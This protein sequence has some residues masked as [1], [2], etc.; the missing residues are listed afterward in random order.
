MTEPFPNYL[1]PEPSTPAAYEPSQT[2]L[3]LLDFHVGI[4]QRFPDSTALSAV[5]MTAQLRHW[6]RAFGIIVIHAL[7][8]PTQSPAPTTKGAEKLSSIVADMV[9]SG[10]VAEPA[11]LVERRDDWDLT[12]T[13]APGVVSALQSPGLMDCLRARGIKSL[14]LCGLSTSGAVLRTAMPATDAGF[15]VTVV[16]DGCADPQQ[17]VHEM[18]MGKLLPSRAWVVTH[19]QWRKGYEGFHAC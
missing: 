4:I 7:V 12:F 8:N 3:L 19:D 11:E 10:G 5:H 9:A 6:A 16:E 18:V 1:D 17:D 15:V 2:A 14:V 13:R